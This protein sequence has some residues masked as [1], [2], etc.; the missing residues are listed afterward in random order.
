M[1]FLDFLLSPLTGGSKNQTTTSTQSLPA[2]QENALTDVYGRAFRAADQ[3]YTP[4]PNPRVAGLTPTQINA[5]RIADANVGNYGPSVQR[6]STYTAA[7]AGADALG[8]ASP[9]L[10][11]A[12]ADLDRAASL[13]GAGA[14]FPFLGQAGGSLESAA[15]RSSLGSAL[16]FLGAGTDSLNRAT[17]ASATAAGTPTIQRGTGTLGTAAD[18]TLAG[19]GSYVDAYR[20]YENPYRDQ[21][22]DRIA[23]TTTRNLL[24]RVLPGVNDTFTGAGQFGSTRNAE[25]TNRAIRDTANEVAGNVSQS[26]ERGYGTSANIYGADQGRRLTAGSALS[27]I[28]S[29]LTSAGTAQGNL[30]T[31]DRQTDI[32]VGRAFNDAAGTTGSLANMDRQGDTAIAGQYGDLGRTAGSL[33]TADRQSGIASANARANIGQATGNLTDANAR[34]QLDA[35]RLSQSEA[36]G[37]SALGRADVGT[38][39]QVGGMQQNQNQQNLDVLNKDFYEQ[40]DFD[41]NNASFLSNIVRGNNTGS[42]TTASAPGPSALSQLAG[43]GTAI[44]GLSR[45]KKGGPAKATMAKRPAP[46]RKMPGR[47]IMQGIGGMKLGVA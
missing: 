16:S 6:A 4:N 33:T 31:A 7:G 2:F 23:E 37:L 5:F 19:T 36:Q 27:G 44:Y 42:T 28:G 45:L 43:L 11:G 39:L 3:P 20:E 8:A 32:A 13:S 17:N 41:R 12:S 26:L 14:A 1:A 22:T 29:N 21:V 40:R 38:L 34:R 18:T 35:G 10:G 47:P 24:E 9:F 30:A 25:F 46:G 15:G